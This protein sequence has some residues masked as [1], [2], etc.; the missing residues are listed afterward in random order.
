MQLERPRLKDDA[1]PTIFPGYP[2]YLTKITT[3]SS[4]D[5]PE[6]RNIRTEERNIKFAL[7]L[8]LKS[9]EEY[10][11]Q[12]KFE[13]IKELY[14]CL[15]KHKPSVF[16][17]IIER[18][19]SVIFLNLIT[20]SGSVNMGYA[21]H[22]DEQLQLNLSYKGK[23]LNHFSSFKFPMC[24]KY[25]S[26]IFNVLECIETMCDN[27]LEAQSFVDVI[28]SL[29]DKLA[30]TDEKLKVINF[31]KEQITLFA[32]KPQKYRYSP[33]TL[34]FASMFFFNLS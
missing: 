12:R 21:V 4:R 14:E 17:D 18:K 13:N 20:H 32:T 1:V 33:E 27:H 16:W 29:L 26:D 19:D 30:E 10:D 3:N 9:K 8:S 34:I 24:V 6:T 15:K 7:D 25:I 23:I 11:A 22:I 31:L 28:I 5:D 2:S